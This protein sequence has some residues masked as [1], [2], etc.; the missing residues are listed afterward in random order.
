MRWQN[1]DPVAFTAMTADPHLNNTSTTIRRCR[2]LKCSD[3]LFNRKEIVKTQKNDFYCIAMAI[4][5]LAHPR[6]VRINCNEE[7]KTVPV[8]MNIQEVN[9]LSDIV[10]SKELFHKSCILQNNNC[11][12]FT[13]CNVEN[14]ICSRNIESVN[15]TL[16]EVMFHAINQVF[17]PIYLPKEQKLLT[18]DKYG[19]ELYFKESKIDKDTEYYIISK[20]NPVNYVQ[21][22]NLFKCSDNKYISLSYICYHHNDCQ[23]D[24]STDEANCVCNLTDRDDVT[25]KFGVRINNKIICSFFYLQT[26]NNKCKLYNELEPLSHSLLKNTN[27][28]HIP[29]G[30]ENDTLYT[31]SEICRYVLNDSHKLIPCENGDHLQICTKFECNMMF[32]CPMFYC[33]PWNYVCDGKWDC[34]R[35]YDEIIDSLCS[36]GKHCSNMFKCRNSVICIHLRDVV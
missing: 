12:L 23:D 30:D 5:N 17:P 16:F 2:L 8:C 10:S 26:A 15:I 4:Y 24:M 36:E 13:W 19:N 25:C 6:W 11:Y 20:E 35:G 22:G 34:P 32:K 29:C 3:V 9:N 31:V 33:I 18:Y 28:K 14:T 21:G 1:K 7:I 27:D